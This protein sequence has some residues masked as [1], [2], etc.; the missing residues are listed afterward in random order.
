MFKNLNKKL[1]TIALSTCVLFT[2]SIL[3][4]AAASDYL[5]SGGYEASVVKDLKFVVSGGD[6][7]EQQNIMIAGANAWNGIS[8]AVNLSNNSTGARMSIWKTSTTTDQ[9]FGE[10]IQYNSWGSKVSTSSTWYMTDINF[11]NNQF[12]IYKAYIPAGEYDARR[13]ASVTHEVGHALSLKHAD[14]DNIDG[15][16]DTGMLQRPLTVQDQDKWYLRCK[17]GW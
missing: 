4:Y 2:G 6:Y 10:C 3:A 1:V 14:E 15:V 8:S 7:N 5:F 12:E 11:Y 13:K 9:L 16:M 17:W